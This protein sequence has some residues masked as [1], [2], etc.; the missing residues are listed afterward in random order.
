VKEG[1]V[2]PST[3]EIPADYKKLDRPKAD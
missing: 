1:Q 3:F 2:E